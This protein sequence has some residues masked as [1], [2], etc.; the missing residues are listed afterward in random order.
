MQ[1]QEQQQ[2][3]YACFYFLSEEGHQLEVTVQQE[4]RGFKAGGR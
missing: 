3:L 1:K 2:V 4:I